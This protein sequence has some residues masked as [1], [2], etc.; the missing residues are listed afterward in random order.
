MA[1]D[2][3]A[4]NFKNKDVDKFATKFGKPNTDAVPAPAY[5]KGNSSNF[6]G[7]DRKRESEYMQVNT[8]ERLGA[9]KQADKDLNKSLNAGIPTKGDMR[10][11]DRQ[12]VR[13]S[14]QADKPYQETRKEGVYKVADKVD[15]FLGIGKYNRDTGGKKN[16]NM[17]GNKS[18]LCVDK[19]GQKKQDEDCKNPNK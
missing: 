18:K 15:K 16:M 5:T 8:R 1:I 13:A 12:S 10:R 17:G 11:E 7:T 2:Y 19:P 14:K 3:N 4:I 6:A 9:E